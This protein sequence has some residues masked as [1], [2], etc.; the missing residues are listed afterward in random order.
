MRVEDET[1]A[2]ESLAGCAL[3]IAGLVPAQAARAADRL[4]GAWVAL[5]SAAAFNNS[6][7][8]YG[9]NSRLGVMLGVRHK[10]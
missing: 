4:Q 2:T 7:N 10:F 8:T 6:G 1:H 3:S 5:N 9:N